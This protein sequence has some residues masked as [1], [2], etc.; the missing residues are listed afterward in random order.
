MI[1]E[2]WLIAVSIGII[3][4]AFVVLVIY[5]ILALLSMKKMVNDFD[6][7]VH[8]FDPLF[9]ILTKA[10]TVIEKKTDKELAEVEE[11]ML[12]ERAAPQP[13]HKR[14]GMHAAI[15]VAEWALVGL[16]LWQKI[17]ERRR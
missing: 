2:H 1:W 14:N 17:R 9:R 13:A 7:K 11:E 10:G 5:V 12:R 16:T 8:S 4:I 15:E 6:Q 3:A